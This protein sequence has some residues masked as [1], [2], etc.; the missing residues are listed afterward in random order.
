MVYLYTQQNYTI[1]FTFS[2]IFN[3]TE[4]HILIEKSWIETI[5]TVGHQ[6][7]KTN[8]RVH[9]RKILDETASQHQQ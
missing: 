7:Y 8:T 4:V 1:K 9:F 2:K 3:D 5:H 6:F